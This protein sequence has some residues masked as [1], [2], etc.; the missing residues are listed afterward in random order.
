M[1]QF[2]DEPATSK[3]FRD[4]PSGLSFLRGHAGNFPSHYDELKECAQYVKYTANCVVGSLCIG[5]TIAKER[6]ERVRLVDPKTR[7]HCSLADV[8]ARDNT[9]PLC[10]V[11][12]SYT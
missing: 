10:I 6:L 8:V 3:Y 11:G 7:A 4:V 9:R 1:R 5:D 2:L 12:S